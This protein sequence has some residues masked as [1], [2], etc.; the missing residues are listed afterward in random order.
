MKLLSN[1]L[2][3]SVY[4]FLV[5]AAAFFPVSLVKTRT[6]NSH[7]SVLGQS[8]GPNSL[9]VRSEDGQS[10]RVISV[11]GLAYPGQ[12]SY[13]DNAFKLINNTPENQFYKLA[14]LKVYPLNRALSLHFGVSGES[15]KVFLRPGQSIT[16]GLWLESLESGGGSPY[17]FTAQIVTLNLN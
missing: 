3:F 7:L 9:E 2:L 1:F 10:G 6:P 5:S 8:T 11:S 4:V 15:Q 16:I 13:Y 17:K 12:N 14:V